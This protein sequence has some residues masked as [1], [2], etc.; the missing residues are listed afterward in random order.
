MPGPTTLGERGKSA[1]LS[2]LIAIAFLVTW[3]ALTSTTA[4]P[5]AVSEYDQ[6]LASSEQMAK[7]P[8][9]ITIAS[10]SVELLGDP[11]YDRGPNDKGIGLQLLFSIGRVAAGYILALMVAI[12]LGFVIGM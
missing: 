12:P 7:V 4:G 6:L 3:Q 11:F 2:V 1:L 5:E 10:R 9:P 8:S